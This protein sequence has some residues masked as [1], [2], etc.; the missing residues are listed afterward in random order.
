LKKDLLVSETEK[1]K[2]MEE[3][4]KEMQDSSKKATSI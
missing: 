3:I 1:K 2:K 4:K